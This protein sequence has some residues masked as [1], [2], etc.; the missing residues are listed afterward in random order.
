MLCHLCRV[1]QLI[2]IVIRVIAH[3][4]YVEKITLLFVYMTL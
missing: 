3:G 4:K 2:D 1:V